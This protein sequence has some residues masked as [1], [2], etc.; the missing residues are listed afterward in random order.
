MFHLLDLFVEIY[1]KTPEFYYL[2]QL[3]LR[4]RPCRNQAD[5]IN[6]MARSKIHLTFF[7]FE[8]ECLTQY[9]VR[10]K[11]N[12]NVSVEKVDDSVREYMF[13]VP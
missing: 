10:G 4:D 12:M 2:L 8:C 5:P 7:L 6:K 3:F 13:K 11:F 9:K 1:D